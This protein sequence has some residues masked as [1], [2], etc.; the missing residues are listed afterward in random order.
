MSRAPAPAKP[1]VILDQTQEYKS[2]SA[3]LKASFKA[4]TPPLNDLLSDY[5]HLQKV[6]NLFSAFV[7]VMS[8]EHITMTQAGANLID[9][10]VR[11][12]ISSSLAMAK[13]SA[14][15]EQS[16]ENLR[17]SID[18]QAQIDT[19]DPDELKIRLS[20]ALYHVEEFAAKDKEHQ[21]E[22]ASLTQEID[23]LYRESYKL[24]E[25]FLQNK[26]VYEDQLSDY[27]MKMQILEDRFQ[28]TTGNLILQKETADNLRKQ[29]DKA[30]V[31]IEAECQENNKLR[32]QLLEKKKLLQKAKQALDQSKHQ[33]EESQIN[34]KRLMIELEAAKGS[35]VVAPPP[36]NKDALA[37]ENVELKRKVEELSRINEEQDKQI[38]EIVR[39]KQ[40]ESDEAELQIQQLRDELE[41]RTENANDEIDTLNQK[42]ADLIEEKQM[43]QDQLNEV[44]ELLHNSEEKAEDLQTKLTELKKVFED[45]NITPEDIP[46]I[47]SDSREN[48][49]YIETIQKLR[50]SLDALARFVEKVIDND[51]NVD[52]EILNIEHENNVI[53]LFED[54]ELRTEVL[55][56]IAGFRDFVKQIS[57]EDTDVVLL[58]D[59]IFGFTDNIQALIDNTVI[60]GENNIYTALIVLVALLNKAQKYVGEQRQ[61]LSAAYKILPFKREVYTSKDLA[62]YME[63]LQVPLRRMKKLLQKEF[64]K[65]DANAQIN[66]LFTHFLDDFE[67]LLEEFRS[68]VSPLINFKRKIH[69]M[70]EAIRTEIENLRDSVENVRIT[71]ENA[72]KNT[73]QQYEQTIQNIRTEMEDVKSKDKVTARLREI[74]Q[75]KDE[76]IKKIKDELNEANDSRAETENAFNTFHAQKEEVELN[77]NV[78]KKQRDRLQALLEQRTNSFKERLKEYEM[79]AEKKREEELARL[80]KMHTIEKD[81]ITEKL[82]IKTKKLQD[83]KKQVKE[84]STSYENIIQ[85][86]RSEMQALVD[87]N[88]RLTRKLSKCKTALESAQNSPSRAQTSPTSV[89][90]SSLSINN[91]PNSVNISSQLTPNRSMT[92]QQQQSPYSQLSAAQYG[93]PGQYSYA[94]SSARNTPG[95]S[96]GVGRST[97]PNR[98]AASTAVQELLQELGKLLQPYTG[99]KSRWTKPRIVATISEVVQ[100]A[101]GVRTVDADNEW[102]KWAAS[103]IASSKGNLTPNEMR[104]MIKD[105]VAGTSSRLKLMEKLQSLRFQKKTL[106][107]RSLPKRTY[108][109]VCNAKTLMSVVI[110]SI[111]LAKAVKRPRTNVI[112]NLN[113]PRATTISNN[114]S[115]TQRTSS[116]IR[117]SR[118]SPFK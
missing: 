44:N 61:Q 19:D 107:T 63:G 49:K 87:Q 22:S 62:D 66:E 2:L 70:P 45:N 15:T 82:E 36:T 91:T 25:K 96:P 83:L 24:K 77:A 38:Q 100:K 47:L 48:P 28:E 16:L 23:E 32:K 75:K 31:E 78:I 29:Y 59:A 101:S 93:T 118:A 74:I 39:V 80:N 20:E 113:S 56:K 53:P 6:G 55:D 88:S 35:P 111:T 26:R 85:H 109:L 46:K 104:S 97:S 81:S 21:K 17:N 115:Q 37:S 4:S 105:M 8:N 71:S 89:P 116:S 108:P 27:Q 73:S 50:S 64:G 30:V 95:R 69:Q 99:Q 34:Q 42:N 86:Q 68:E 79:R 5:P 57:A 103:L 72:L 1:P 94:T 67:T 60:K 11:L 40:E 33:I 112:S 41:T 54:T 84:V 76:A 13:S 7:S 65:F 90:I 51:G 98:Q 58:Y 9:H 3:N 92:Q 110:V 10:T 43:V 102:Q 52:P 18:I 14:L 114:E 117:G 12:L 106:L